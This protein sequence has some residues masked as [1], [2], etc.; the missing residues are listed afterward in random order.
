MSVPRSNDL[1]NVS[2]AMKKEIIVKKIEMVCE[3]QLH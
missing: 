1:K 2:P 3:A